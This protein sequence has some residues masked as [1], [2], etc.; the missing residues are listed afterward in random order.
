MFGVIWTHGDTASSPS[1][2]QCASTTQHIPL[3]QALPMLFP[4]MDA[5]KMNIIWKQWIILPRPPNMCLLLITLVHYSGMSKQNEWPGFRSLC[6]P[7]PLF[8]THYSVS[9]WSTD[10]C[11]IALCKVPCVLQ[12]R[13]I[14]TATFSVNVVWDL[15][16]FP[17]PLSL[18][19]VTAL[20]SELTYLSNQQVSYD[21]VLLYL[22]PSWVLCREFVSDFNC[23]F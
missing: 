14:V 7:P 15:D 13:T 21:W 10:V 19:W 1:C 18:L 3:Q 5:C 17:L 4:G 20:F 9:S 16:V 11:F 6:I 8:P 12:N 2:L 22:G 23:S